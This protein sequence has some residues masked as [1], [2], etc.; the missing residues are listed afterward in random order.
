MIKEI[1]VWFNFTNNDV[2][3]DEALVLSYPN[4]LTL[5]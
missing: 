2:S 1:T 4:S 3:E 5:Q